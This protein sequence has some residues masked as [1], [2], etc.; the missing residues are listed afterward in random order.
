MPLLTCKDITVKYENQIVIS[1]LSLEINEGDYLCI[2][3]DNGTGKTTLLKAMLGLKNVHSGTISFDA[4]MSRN[5]I[6]YISQQ[7]DINR[8]FPASV[9]E[10]VLSGCLNKH[11]LAPLYTHAEK[12][13]AIE[14]MEK[15]GVEAIR[16]KCFQD[17]S[18]GQQ[19]RV[20][21]ARA[22]MASSRILF[23]DEPVAAL[24]PIATADFYQ[25]L[26]L[27]R[28]DGLTIIMVSH[29][30]H[31]SIHNASHILH[32]SADSYFFGTTADYIASSFGQTY[33]G[34]QGICR[35]CHHTLAH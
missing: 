28:T 6:G 2:V 9:N 20:L 18:G 27:L 19:R 17:L 4:S 22:M 29:D 34:D 35:E 11:G 25:L 1:G 3:G 26:N 33:L 16:T 12:A 7:N 23:L 32:L 31:S 30:I 21:L 13:A 24:D 14:V 15:L 10:V 5:E 8:D